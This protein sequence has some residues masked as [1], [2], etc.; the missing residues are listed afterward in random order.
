MAKKVLLIV[1]GSVLA[2]IG[3]GLA[4]GGAVL[5]ALTGGDGYFGS[6]TQ[7]LRTPTRALVSEPQGMYADRGGIEATVRLRVTATSGQPVFLG[8][9][10][11]AEVDRYLAGSSYDEVV[12]VEFSPFRYST[13]R[14]EGERELPPPANEPLWTAQAT[15]TG[16]QTLEIRVGDGDYRVV[17]MN[18]D[19]AEVVQVRASFGIRVPFLRG[20]GIGLL[21]G[22]VIGLLVGITLLVLGVRAKV[23]PRQ[24]PWSPYGPGYGGGYGPGPGAPGYGPPPGWGQPPGYAAPPPSQQSAP[25]GQPPPPGRAE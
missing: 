21:V 10:P 14:H 22:G 18:A 2:L 7:T 5:V 19:A 1:F 9:G 8:A 6:D 25:P 20:L 23:P 15:G 16:E 4:I 24:P 3:A 12:D 13:V 17:V 11:T